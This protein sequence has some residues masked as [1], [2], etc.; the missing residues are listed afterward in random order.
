MISGE[1]TSWNS[2]TNVGRARIFL[3]IAGENKSK[4]RSKVA[5]TLQRRGET[6]LLFY[7]DH[8]CGQDT[9]FFH[10]LKIYNFHLIF[11]AF[12]PSMNDFLSEATDIC[13]RQ[14]GLERLT[15][16]TFFFTDF[17]FVINSYQYFLSLLLLIIIIIL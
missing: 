3:E 8:P 1:N 11:A 9:P 12:Y 15:V 14:D 2:K 7:F 16:V 6:N 4:K 17:D 10:T 5:L 13:N